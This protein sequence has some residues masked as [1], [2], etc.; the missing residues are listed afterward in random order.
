[1]SASTHAKP[2][3]AELIEQGWT[4]R[5]VAAPARLN[6]TV[7]LYQSLGYEVHLEA[8]GAEELNDEC[9]SCAVALG[10]YRVV[11]TRPLKR[12]EPKGAFGTR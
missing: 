11:Y 12:E 4:R 6:E 9:R 7:E 5:F 3:E 1:L 10:L 2:K 8:Q